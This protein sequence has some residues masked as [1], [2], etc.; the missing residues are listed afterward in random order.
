MSLESVI[1]RLAIAIEEN[2]KAA[3]LVRIP[4]TCCTTTTDPAEVEA[5]APAKKPAKKVVPK[6]VAKKKAPPVEEVEDEE[7][8]VEVEEVEEE[9]AEEEE[10]EEEATFPTDRTAALTV[11]TEFV[12]NAFVEAGEDGGAA[13][14]KFMKLRE[15][16]GVDRSS[17]VP[18]KLLEKFYDDTV[19]ALS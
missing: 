14:A 10:E 19:A 12:R 17:E 8:E 15:S 3:G 16:Y 7:E 18:D 1:E 5:P 13:K 9:E 11:I 6:K 4:T 2:T